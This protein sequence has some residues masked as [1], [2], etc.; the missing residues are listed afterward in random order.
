MTEARNRFAVI[1]AGMSGILSGIKLTEAGHPFTIFEKADRVGGTWRENTYPGIAC[2]VPSHIY[3]YSFDLNPDW[4]HFCSPGEEI[5]R[6]FEGAV[7]RFGIADHIRFGDE[8]VSCE[9]HEADLEWEVTTAAEH[10]ERFDWVIAATGILHRPKSP[11]IEGLDTFAGPMFHTAR[12]DHDID[13]TGKRV[14]MIG[15]GSSS[16]QI[17]GAVA[18]RVEKLAIFQR[19][20]QWV[21]PVEQTA[22]TDEQKQ[23][24]RTDADVLRDLHEHMSQAFNDNFATDIIDASSGIADRFEEQ[25]LEML[26]RIP[27]PVLREKLTPDYRAGCK[28]LI[29][30]HNY[31][32]AI[33]A[34]SVDVVT[35]TIERIEPTGVRTVDGV[36]HE[37][38][39]L[40]LATGFHVDAFMRPMSVS[41]RDGVTLDEVW[42]D[43]P[44]AYMAVAVPEFPNFFMLNGPN[45]PV[46]NFSLIQT[47]E[48]Q[49]AYAMSLV[50]EVHKGRL[51]YAVPTAEAAARFEDE[52][53]EAAKTTVWATG[54]RSWYLDKNGVPFAWPFPFERFR[55][56]MAEP[57]LGDFEPA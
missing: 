38:D 20:A 23:A 28:R 39:V 16:V 31:Y 21:V 13:L 7:E 43:W 48:L 44:K 36:L 37:I 30:S 9:W 6:Y 50:D 10:V 34:P 51:R 22:Y 40:V 3:S 35:D 1:G 12:W 49:F 11:D 42:A 54:C 45:S 32:D 29:V 53:V 33:V 47:A 57:R 2:D 26:A 25:C 56:E 24:F 15:T 46:G 5:Q 55:M 41:G 17:T 27:D 19:T 8:V 4:S 14:G 52:R 18:E